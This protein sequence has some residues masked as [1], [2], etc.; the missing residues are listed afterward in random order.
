MYERG[1]GKKRRQSKWRKNKGKDR[2]SGLAVQTSAGAWAGGAAASNS[3]APGRLVKGVAVEG[4]KRARKEARG[5]RRDL[6]EPSLWAACLEDGRLRQGSIDR[7]PGVLYPRQGRCYCRSF[8]MLA[9][10]FFG[11]FCR[12]RLPLSIPQASVK[13]RERTSAVVV[14]AAA[15]LA[16]S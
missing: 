15:R 6:R 8:G 4:W 12:S 16:F 10:S 5:R 11:F 3:S 13:Q 9:K 1:K 2:Y 14:P 7:A